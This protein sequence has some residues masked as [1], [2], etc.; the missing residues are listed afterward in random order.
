MYTGFVRLI[1]LL[2]CPGQ[3]EG[4]LSP[5]GGANGAEEQRGE[6]LTCRSGFREEE[7]PKAGEREWEGAV[8]AGWGAVRQNIGLERVGLELVGAGQTDG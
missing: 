5:R 1:S 2:L 7:V 8:S 6:N 3:A 4:A